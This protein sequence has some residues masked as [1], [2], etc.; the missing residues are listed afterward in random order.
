M[1]TKDYYTILQVQPQATPNDIKAA[2]RRLALTHHPDRDKDPQ[3]TLKM[4]LVN[5]AYQILGDPLKRE[6]YDL[7]RIAELDSEEVIEEETESDV[8][9]GFSAAPPAP[10]KQPENKDFKTKE[11]QR[12]KVSPEQQRRWVLSQLMTI[13]QIS[14]LVALFFGLSLF[15]GYVNIPILV[16][17]ILAS[18]YSIVT[19]VFKE[20]RSSTSSDSS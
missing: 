20:R 18:L 3:A 5:E 2:Y 17:L 7:E 12:E 13:A 16:T 1:E 10:E 19:I 6:Q 11:D 15:I 14:I 4:Q 8:D 9:P